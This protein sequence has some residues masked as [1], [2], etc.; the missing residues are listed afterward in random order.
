MPAFSAFLL[1]LGVA[2][3]SLSLRT[4]Q[5]PVLQKLGAIGILFT[6]YLVGE[7]LTGSWIAG[8]LCAAS[9]F[10]LP[11]V[12]LLTRIRKLSMPQERSLR[13]RTPPNSETFPALRELTE[14]VEE[15]GF[16]HVDDV[17]WEWD[18]YQQ[19]FRILYKADERAHATICLIEQQDIAFYFLSLSSRAPDGTTWTTWN[20]PFS[21]SLKLVPQWRVNRLRGDQ[22]FLQLLESHR[23]FLR[24]NG[25]STGML[26]DLGPEQIQE[27]IQKDL[28]A[29]ISHNIAKGVLRTNESGEVRYSWRGL[30]YLWFQFLR[31]IVRLS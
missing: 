10:F 24:Q 26:A 14:D 28:R 25:I 1:I 8:V 11:W 20:Y 27:E 9:W 30:L 17:G 6:S 21:Y 29:Q 15:E 3:L 2:A 18:E 5:S 13:Q 31:D 12:D 22:T 4:F 16:E 7:S 19:F 23:H